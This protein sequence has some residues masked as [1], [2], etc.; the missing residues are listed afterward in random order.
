M[1]MTPPGTFTVTVTIS[2]DD[3]STTVTNTVTVTAPTPVLAP[4]IALVDQLV[5]ARKI[6][7]DFGN[8]LKAELAAA[9]GLIDRG[10]NATATMLLKAVVLE[11]DLL[12]RLRQVSAADVAPLRTPAHAGDLD[13]ALAGQTE[14]PS[15]G[16]RA[17]RGHRVDRF[18]ARGRDGQRDLRQIPRLVAARLRQRLEIARQ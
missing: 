10:K 5:A 12:V 15:R 18:A 11:L 17:V 2:D 6:P 13:A 3:T 8:V 16:G 7:R 9:Q 1:S 4:A 14:E